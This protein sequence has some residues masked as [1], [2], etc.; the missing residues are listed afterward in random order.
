M[1]HPG[2]WTS[3][4]ITLLS[5][6][7]LCIPWY[8]ARTGQ[9]QDSRSGIVVHVVDGDTLDV[10]GLGRVRLVGINAPEVGQP[11]YEEAKSFLTQLCLGEV[12]TVDVDDRHPRDRYGRVLAVIIVDGRNVNAELLNEGLAEILYI[13]PSEFDPWSWLEGGLGD[14]S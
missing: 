12:V 9:P 6:G 5:T 14:G 8:V 4:A 13:P 11:G 3:L 10:E 2:R 7:M 1:A